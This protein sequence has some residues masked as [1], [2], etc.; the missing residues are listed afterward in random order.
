MFGEETEEEKKVAEERAAA[1]K[2]SGKKK[3]CE[4][5]DLFHFL[6]LEFEFKHACVLCLLLF[7][8]LTYVLIGALFLCD[9]QLAS[10]QFCWM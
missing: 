8:L 1:V 2:A 9:D 4:F 6:I 3:E 7:S 10:H 5:V